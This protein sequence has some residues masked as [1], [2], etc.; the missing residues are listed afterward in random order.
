M[1]VSHNSNVTLQVY[2]LPLYP[3]LDKDIKVC[4]DIDECATKRPCDA[5]GLCMNTQEMLS[6]DD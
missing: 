6:F 2:S 1:Q 5:N 4:E 3:Y